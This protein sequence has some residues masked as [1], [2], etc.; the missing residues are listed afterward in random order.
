MAGKYTCEATNGLSS[1]SAV[2]YLML[3]SDPACKYSIK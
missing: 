3:P 2:A 1:E